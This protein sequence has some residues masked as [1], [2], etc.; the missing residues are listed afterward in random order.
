MGCR[1][2][3]WA[4]L[5]STTPGPTRVCVHTPSPHR[6]SLPRPLF[7]PYAVAR[8][9]GFRG[10][11]AVACTVGPQRLHV[12]MSSLARKQKCQVAAP[13]CNPTQHWGELGSDPL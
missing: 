12:P 3:G 9:S 5:C 7:P 1:G 8:P 6:L 13:G 2:Q 4:L 11:C 10:R